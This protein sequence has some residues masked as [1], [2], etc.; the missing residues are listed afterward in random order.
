MGAV[1]VELEKIV[2]SDGLC[3]WETL[4]DEARLPI[5]RAL[6]PSETVECVAY[7]TSPEMLAEVVAC[8]HKNHWP[9]LPCGAAS[10]LHWGGLAKNIRL[11]VSTERM[12]RLVDHA[13][14]DLTVTAEAGLCR[15]AT[16]PGTASAVPGA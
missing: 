6:A 12:N 11:V 16:H 8:A 13:I 10:K 7:P 5:L 4:S 3:V 2:G 15:P 14:G 1:A 9:L